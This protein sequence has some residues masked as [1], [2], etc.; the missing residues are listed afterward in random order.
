VLVVE[1]Q[2]DSEAAE[3]VRRLRQTIRTIVTVVVL[4]AIVAGAWLY[5]ER[6]DDRQQRD[7]ENFVHCIESP[8]C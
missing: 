6:S 2:R 7:A 5:K 8:N 4:L 3:E 1:D